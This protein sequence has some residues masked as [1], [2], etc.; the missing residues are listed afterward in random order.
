MSQFSTTEKALKML[1]SLPR[2]SLANIRDNPGS[3]QGVSVP[4][5]DHIYVQL[6]SS[7]SSREN[8]VGLN[9]EVTNMEQATRDL[10]SDRTTCV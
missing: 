6:N 7:V 10:V 5:G 3:R 1:R 2:V 4:Q 8:A 9:T